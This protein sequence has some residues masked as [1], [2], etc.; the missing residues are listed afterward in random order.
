YS[1]LGKI[2]CRNKVLGLIRS[3]L[4]GNL[5]V[6]DW[7]NPKEDIL[8]VGVSGD[9]SRITEFGSYPR[10]D[11]SYFI[12]IINGASGVDP[13]IVTAILYILCILTGIHHI[14]LI[15]HFL[16]T[17]GRIYI[18]ARLAI[19]ASFGGND[20]YTVGS[21]GSV[22]RRGRSIFQD[23]YGFNVGRIDRR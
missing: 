10:G 3:S 5:Q 6:T 18:D 21:P 2:T 13:C 12:G 17:I 19:T 7:S 15:G 22:Y 20:D 23:F 4:R 14:Q 9:R 8:P 1:F 11:G 16:K